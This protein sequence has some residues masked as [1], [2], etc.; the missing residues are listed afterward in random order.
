LVDYG[1]FGMHLPDVDLVI[2]DPADGYV[3]AVGPPVLREIN[4]LRWPYMSV[5]FSDDEIHKKPNEFSSLVFILMFSG[6]FPLLTCTVTIE[7]KSG[8]W[9]VWCETG[10]FTCF[11]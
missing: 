4:S 5:S 6:N 10:T 2:F 1:E 3:L 8:L 11:A 9:A 7:A